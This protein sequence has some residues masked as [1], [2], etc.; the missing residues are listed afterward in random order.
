MAD[1]KERARTPKVTVGMLLERLRGTLQLEDLEPGVGSDR[2]VATAEVS[3]PGLVLAGYV[4]RFTPG[5]LQVLGETEITYLESLSEPKRK[6]IL[7][8]F[9]SFPIPAVFVSKG[10]RLPPG[11]RE[12]ASASHP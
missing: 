1:G 12:A 7:D 11:L 5:R 4:E 2:V 8:L 10:Q 9:F 6:K 3:S